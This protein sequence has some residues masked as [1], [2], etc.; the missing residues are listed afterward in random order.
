MAILSSA[1]Q[2]KSRNIEETKTTINM[3]HEDAWLNINKK[4]KHIQEES[5]A[6]INVTH[7]DAWLNINKKIKHIKEESKIEDE[8]PFEST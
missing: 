3:T 2:R 5:K 1:G 4:I 8:E 7:E 6:M